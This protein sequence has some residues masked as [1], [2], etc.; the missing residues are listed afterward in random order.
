MHELVAAPPDHHQGGDRSFGQI[1]ADHLV[2]A[3]IACELRNQT[4][5]VQRGRVVGRRPAGQFAQGRQ[6][7]DQ[8]GGMCNPPRAQI[9]RAHARS[10]ESGRQ[11]RRS[12]SCTRVRA[13]PA[14]R[15]DRRRAARRYLRKARIGERREQH[16][17]LIVH[18]GNRAIVGAPR[19]A[20]WASS[21]VPARDRRH[22]AAAANAD[23]APRRAMLTRGM[24]ISFRQIDPSNAVESHKGHA[25][26]SWK[27]PCKTAD[28]PWHLAMSKSF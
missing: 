23:R 3:R 24:S 1:L 4:L 25:D 17:D 9:A 19:G 5:A 18:I 2:P 28:H 10:M 21:R 12:S 11:A 14:C 13:R 8:R 26:G 20:D 16:A 6:Q 15:R 27:R 22:A 7:V